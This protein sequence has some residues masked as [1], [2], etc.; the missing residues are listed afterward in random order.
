MGRKRKYASDAERQAAYRARKAAGEPMGPS[1]R[2]SDPLLRRLA[3]V[4]TLLE[5]DKDGERD[6]AARMAAQIKRSSGRSWYDL[7][8]I[9]E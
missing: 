8:G 9:K 6:A 3:K 7:L 2:D 1:R 5:S 4:L